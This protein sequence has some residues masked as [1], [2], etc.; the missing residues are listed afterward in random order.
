M[1]Y[2][3]APTMAGRTSLR[4]VTTSGNFTAFNYFIDTYDCDGDGDKNNLVNIDWTTTGVL[5]MD[6][7]LCHLKGY[8]Y[9]AR[10]QMLR[11]SR[12]DASRPVGAGIAAPNVAVSW[13]TAGYGTRVIYN[14]MMEDDGGSGNA[15]LSDTILMN[16]K[17]SPPS[18]N[19]AFCHFD[20]PGVDWK[21]RGDNWK[22][23]ADA[24]WVVQCM[25]CHQGKVG[26]D[27]GTSGNATA[28]PDYKALGLCDPAKGHEPYSN[29]WNAKDDSIKTCEDCHLRAGYDSGLGEY[30][31]DYGAPDPTGKH[32]AYG[33]LGNICQTGIDGN[34]TTHSTNHLG[35]VHCTGCHVRKVADEDWNTGGAVVDATGTDAA[36]RQA[37]HENDSVL[38]K[39]KKNL[40][41]QW[42]D[43][44]V[45]PTG[46]LTTLYWRDVGTEDVNNDGNP[47]G[48]DVPLT[49]HVSAVNALFGQAAMSHD[50]SGQLTKADF[51][52]R[53]TQLENNLPTYNGGGTPDIK[54]CAMAVPFVVT[55]N[56][57][58]AIDALGHSC[59][60]CHSSSSQGLWNGDYRLQGDTMNLSIN[61]TGAADPQVVEMS[62]GSD[63]HGNLKGKTK[64]Q[65]KIDVLYTS[66]DNL[67]NVDRSELLYDDT[68]SV[69]AT[70]AT[71]YAGRVA[72]VGYLNG[73]PE[74]T[75]TY[76]TATVTVSYADAG[77]YDH[78]Y[79]NRPGCNATEDSGCWE[80]G[81]TERPGCNSTDT[82]Q[83]QIKWDMYDCDVYDTLGF[84]AASVGDGATYTWNF[85]DGSGQETGRNVTHQF[86]LLGVC[87][88]VLTVQ[89]MW[90]MV[91]QQMIEVNVQRP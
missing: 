20:F 6:C 7:F 44:K 55:H 60:D 89:D 65:I 3:P 30:S 42:Q 64:S 11:Q 13:A 22:K 53:I 23:E 61:G 50:L 18:K 26:S 8:D 58:P 40:A 67:T 59:S 39:V 32:Q 43:G 52:T 41:Y 16:I 5:E 54:L 72:W 24:H 14:N 75:P 84:N 46:V 29:L 87:K 86:K 69:N 85:A 17:A 21:K 35:V 12:F 51:A 81:M 77:P 56:V 36:G 28:G 2:I 48:Q 45:V 70:D 83:C 63:F 78:T 31:P 47:G 79:P 68:A 4:N 73:I 90:G 25:G 10:T 33:L 27:I 82:S 9:D 88:V 15:T 1:E 66:S 37:D 80:S 38:R 19:C 49:T 74:P 76:P 91:A 57:S 62:P 71:S 34:M